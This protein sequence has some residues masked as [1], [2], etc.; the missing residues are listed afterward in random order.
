MRA[1]YECAFS[2]FVDILCA[3]VDGELFVKCRNDLVAAIKQDFRAT[4][5]D[6]N[7]STLP[8]SPIS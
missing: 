3:S 5:P 7:S 8:L 1:Y 6:G 4:D 2:R